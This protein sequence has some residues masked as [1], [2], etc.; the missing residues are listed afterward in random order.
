[1]LEDDFLSCFYEGCKNNLSSISRFAGLTGFVSIENKFDGISSLTCNKIPPLTE[2]RSNVHAVLKPSI[3]KF[4]TGK[5][6]S[7]LIKAEFL[8]AQCQL[9]AVDICLKN[10]SPTTFVL[11]WFR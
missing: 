1:M 8:L 5:L 4:L 6:S 9:K 11:S 10:K 7:S 3:K 2:S